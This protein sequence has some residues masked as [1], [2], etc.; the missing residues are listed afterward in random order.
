MR[1]Q[2]RVSNL[3]KRDEVL[4]NHVTDSGFL[5]FIML[6]VFGSINIIMD[7]FSKEITWN[8]AMYGLK[9]LGM[10]FLVFIFTLFMLT[11]AQK[12]YFT[13]SSA[14]IVS[15]VASICIG[16]DLYT[17]GMELWIF[18][19]GW[20]LLSVVIYKC[21]NLIFEDISKSHPYF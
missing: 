3:M 18:L 19:F 16:I 4:R 12:E 1:R 6:T 2:N 9:L 10:G 20:V 17:K 15:L 7:I 13:K 5:A 8:I 21:I 14:R 11:K